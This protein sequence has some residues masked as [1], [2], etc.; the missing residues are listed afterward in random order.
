MPGTADLAPPRRWP[1]GRG[2]RLPPA[3]AAPAPPRQHRAVSAAAS[4]PRPPVRTLGLPL[5]ARDA[6]PAPLR[7][8]P[9]VARDRRAALRRGIRRGHGRALPPHLRAPRGRPRVLRAR[10]LD[11]PLQLRHARAGPAPARG[12]AAAGSTRPGGR[13]APLTAQNWAEIEKRWVSPRSRREG[14]KA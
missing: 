3:E 12:V 10:R 11:P 8:R 7:R 13:R 4:R 5:L 1:G 14:T 2:P 9:P 6:R